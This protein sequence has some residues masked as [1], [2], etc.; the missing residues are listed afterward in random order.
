MKS[1]LKKL[2]N[3]VGLFVF[4]SFHLSL[5]IENSDSFTNKLK[6]PDKN[7]PVLCYHNIKSHLDKATAYTISTSNFESHLKMLFDDGYKSILPEDHYEYFL[8]DI[9][10]PDRPVII[11][12]DDTRI[13]HFSI[14]APLLKKYGFKG[15][16]F[17]MTIAIGKKN[18]MT[19]DQIKSLASDGHSI[20]LHTWDHQ[21]LRKLPSADWPKQIDKP[22]ALLENIVGKKV[23]HLSY[24]FGAW[25]ENAIQEVKKR[26]I[27]T[28]Y[29][30]NAKQHS[31]EKL[32]TLR[33]LLVPGTWSATTL[34][35]QIES[36]FK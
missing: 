14:A 16:F 22:K 2:L 30:L 18:Y 26:G 23:E 6:I 19:A 24:P 15:T 27:K 33:R 17:I 12:F 31:T 13:E 10:I 28:A 3:I 7:V 25:N 8:D 1:F 32:H 9:C 20:Q 35:K 21:D 34:K 11:S 5:K 4:L 36:T 29:Q